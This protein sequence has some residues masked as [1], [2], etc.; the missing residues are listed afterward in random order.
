[1]LIDDFTA[2]AVATLYHAVGAQL[3]QSGS[4]CPAPHMELRSQLMFTRQKPFPTS[5]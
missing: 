1:M 4:D 2:F 5:Q 3:I